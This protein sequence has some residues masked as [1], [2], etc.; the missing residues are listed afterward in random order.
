LLGWLGLFAG[1]VNLVGDKQSQ[2]HRGSYARSN[3]FSRFLPK[4]NG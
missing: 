3:G 2:V 1:L 4:G